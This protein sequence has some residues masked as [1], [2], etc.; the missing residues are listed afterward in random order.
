MRR[1][2]YTRNAMFNQSCHYYKRLQRR[3]PSSA[4]DGKSSKSE[5]KH[6]QIVAAPRQLSATA[7]RIAQ[8]TKQ[9]NL[10]SNLGPA[11][12]LP[13]GFKRKREN[14]NCDEKEIKE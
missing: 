2:Y 9:K 1:L 5:S 8:K 4:D 6:N 13:E 14:K 3:L 10:E 12:Q 7:A 11:W